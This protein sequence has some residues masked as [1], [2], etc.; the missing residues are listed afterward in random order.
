[1][2]SIIRQGGGEV[3]GE[4][5][6]P[7][8][9]RISQFRDVVSKIQKAR[10]DAI[11][12]TVVGQGCINFYRAYHKAGG[13]GLDCP[14]GS[15]TANEAEI[16]EIGKAAAVGHITAAPYFRS[17][18]SDA[19]QRF[20]KSYRARFGTTQDVTSCCEAAYCQMHLFARAL[21]RT[22]EMDTDALREALLGM[23]FQA[24][25]GEIKIDPDN[26][27]TYLQSR[28]AT[29][30]DSGEFSIKS[31]VRHMVKPDPYLVHPE[32]DDWSLRTLEVA[33]GQ[34]QG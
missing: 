8:N 30:D 1:M 32:I 26:N 6:V 20:L 19:N 31:M 7:L 11:F 12:S 18:D 29:V 14:I 16:A 27:H 5:Y 3:V 22:R 9:T 23:S 21:A 25:Q 17:I 24:P 33:G 15:L 4:D 28:I 10:P 34:G 2:R 13:S